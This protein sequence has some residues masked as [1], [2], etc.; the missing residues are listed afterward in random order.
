[1]ACGTPVVLSSEPALR[2][3]AG[4]AGVYAEHGDYGAALE[5]ALAERA[6]R[7][8]A[9]LER[10][11]QFTWEAAARLTVQAYREVLGA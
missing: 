11:K 3:V 7:S 8:A 10:A 1:M 6:E 5:R 4:D 9:G 2:E